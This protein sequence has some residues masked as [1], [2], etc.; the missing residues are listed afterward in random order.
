MII[1]PF[2]VSSKQI[3]NIPLWKIDFHRLGILFSNSYISIG[4][5]QPI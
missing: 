4:C 3:K 2:L 1:G 5:F